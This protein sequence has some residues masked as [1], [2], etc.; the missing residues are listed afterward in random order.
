[1][2]ESPLVVAAQ[3]SHDTW[4]GFDERQKRAAVAA[5]AVTFGRLGLRLVVEA[6]T[7][8]GRL[9]RKQRFV[10]NLAL[11]MADSIDGKIARHFDAVTPFGKVADPLADKIDFAIQEYGRVMR[12]ELDA[13]TAAVRSA[14]DLAS[15]HVRHEQ[16]LRAARGEI[17]DADTG[18]RPLNKWTSAFRAAS[19][20]VDDLFPGSRLA[21][22]MQH[23]ATAALIASGLSNVK[24]YR[25]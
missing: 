8:T 14:R 3:Q 5:S 12:G 13:P 23:T 11:D 2:R 21:Q 24:E 16:S 7:R 15:T 4:R 22:G 17:A 6:A 10:A 18:A 25:R 9:S 19:L 1:M 20:R